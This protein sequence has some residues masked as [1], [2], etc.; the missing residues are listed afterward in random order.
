M[1]AAPAGDDAVAGD[2]LF[3]H[4]E[5]GRPVGDEHVVF[6]EAVGIEQHV[7]PLA[8]RQLALAV[9]GVDALLAAAEPRFGPPPVE[10]R[11]DFLHAC[12]PS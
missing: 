4:L 8:R 11:D 6:F 1:I 10:R 9:L 2:D 7:E 5:L 12:L 3:V